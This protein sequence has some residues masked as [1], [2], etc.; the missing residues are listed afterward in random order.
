MSQHQQQIGLFFV[1]C[2]LALKTTSFFSLLPLLSELAL[3]FYLFLF[4]ETSQNGF[5]T[6]VT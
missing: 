6:K 2:D 3:S 5:Y 1:P 4:Q